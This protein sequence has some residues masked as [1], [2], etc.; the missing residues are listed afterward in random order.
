MVVT[1]AGVIHGREP[2]SHTAEVVQR[3]SLGTSGSPR[4]YSHC[5]RPC[6][7]VNQA[8]ISNQ[9]QEPSASKCAPD[10]VELHLL[11]E[12]LAALRLAHLRQLG[13]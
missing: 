11:D 7:L 4:P 6:P 5:C 8:R 12:L 1:S 3:S 9:T 2:C 10:A 13:V